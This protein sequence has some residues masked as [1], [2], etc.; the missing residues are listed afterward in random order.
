MQQKI[1]FQATHLFFSAGLNYQKHYLH[2]DQV[3]EHNLF[4]EQ[5]KLLSVQFEVSEASKDIS[6][7]VLFFCKPILFL[8]MTELLSSQKNPECCY[9]V[10]KK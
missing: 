9:I 4:K 3:T 1:M 8:G 5:P 6:S 7:G 10:S 2:Q